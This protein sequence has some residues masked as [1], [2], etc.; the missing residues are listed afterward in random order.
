MLLNRPPLPLLQFNRPI[1][2][3]RAIDMEDFY[4][5]KQQRMEDFEFG[6]YCVDL[7]MQFL[8]LYS[9]L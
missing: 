9:S 4:F 7:V 2:F 8:F 1:F 6:H 5:E 3:E